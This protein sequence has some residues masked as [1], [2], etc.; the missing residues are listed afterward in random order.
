M[1]GQGISTLVHMNQQWQLD[2]LTNTIHK[3]ATAGRSRRNL[4]ALPIGMSLGKQSEAT[5]F[6]QKFFDGITVYEVMTNNDQQRMVRRTNT[7]QHH[8]LSVG[9]YLYPFQTSHVLSSVCYSKTSHA[10][11][12]GSFQKST[13]CLFSAKHSP[14]CLL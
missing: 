14:M 3:S 1:H 11:F 9:L 4:E 7:T 5:G 12:S 8:P 10:P 2:P 6:H 13:T